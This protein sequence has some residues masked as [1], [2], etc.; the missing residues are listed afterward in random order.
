MLE[1]L[2]L[3]FAFFLCVL[4]TSSLDVWASLPCWREWW[5]FFLTGKALSPWKASDSSF[6]ASEG[7]TQHVAW[8]SRVRK[9]RTWACIVEGQRGTCGS[10]VPTATP[11]GKVRA[12][13][14]AG[15]P[16]GCCG[17][18][19]LAGRHAHRR[20]ATQKVAGGTFL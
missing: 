11:C 17:W 1:L 2:S 16:G 7:G 12:G 20:L 3:V 5:T 14:E 6:S 4:V 19:Q 18:P 13:P 10:V 8:T 9:C 15:T